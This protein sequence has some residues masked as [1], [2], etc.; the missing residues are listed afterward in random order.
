MTKELFD[1]F[2]KPEK[3]YRLWVNKCTALSSFDPALCSGCPYSV[4]NRNK[5]D[6]MNLGI[7]GDWALWMHYYDMNKPLLRRYIGKYKW[8]EETV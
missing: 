5:Y 7:K 8:E 3:I 1:I 4:I 2:P 6:C